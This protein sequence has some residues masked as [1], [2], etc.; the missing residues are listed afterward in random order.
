LLAVVPILVLP[1]AAP[2]QPYP[3]MDRVSDKVIRK[4]QTSSCEQL[5]QEKMQGQGRP[6]PP[7]EQRIVDILRGDPAMRAAF[8]NRIA[9]PKVNKMFECG[10]VP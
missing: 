4:Y 3:M 10:M 7:M 5:W 1:G 8:F 2:A 6:K 9:G